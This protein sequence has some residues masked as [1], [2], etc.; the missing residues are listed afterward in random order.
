MSFVVVCVPGVAGLIPGEVQ[1]KLDQK[2]YQ[3]SVKIFCFCDK[4]V[5]KM[6]Y[7]LFFDGHAESVKIIFR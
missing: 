2:F 4:Y 6:K 5:I 7:V 1:M 3:I